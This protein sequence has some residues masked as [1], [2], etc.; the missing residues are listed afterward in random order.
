MVKLLVFLGV[1][2]GL[3]DIAPTEPI[4][5]MMTDDTAAPS[6]D[7]GPE[8][9]DS[10]TPDTGEGTAS[11]DTGAASNDTGLAD[12]GSASD[13]NSAPKYSAAE[14]A[15]EQGG[16]ATAPAPQGAAWLI[17]LIALMMAGRRR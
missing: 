9:L 16:C 12:T 14:L 4:T 5:A 1:V 17:A 8:G 10:G 7:T 6:S 11:G 15:G 3:M 13:A 2:V